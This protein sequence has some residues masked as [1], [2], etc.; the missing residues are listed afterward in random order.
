MSKNSCCL[1]G[2]QLGL[3]SN[4]ITLKDGHL[5]SKCLKSSGLTS[6]S[7]SKDLLSS[8]VIEV[9]TPRIEAIRTY[10]ITKS[11]DALEIDINNQL[12]KL[13]NTIYFFSNLHSFS[14]HE[15][16]ENLQNAAQGGKAKGA[17][18]GGVVGGLSGGLIG[19]AIG[20]A[21]GEK[22]GGLFLASCDYMYVNI[23]LKGT[24]ETN[25]RIDYIREKTR[26]SSSEYKTALKRANELI[27]GLSIIVAENSAKQQ[28]I[29]ETKRQYS[30]REVTIQNKHL[31]AEEFSNELTI[32]KTLLANGDI[33]VEEF[34]QKKKK[35]LD[36]M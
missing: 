12:F 9:I 13:N 33:T 14:F 21:V 35:L 20:A 23:N 25:V 7:S 19:G 28:A 32:Y 22:V 16:P 29:A 27:D 15:Y 17:A 26:T 1:C 30:K 3:F 34:E 10:H 4:K 6:I 8:Q 31:T 2:T 18:I 5:C 11:F 24:F 36:M